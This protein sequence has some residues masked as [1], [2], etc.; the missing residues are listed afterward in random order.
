MLSVVVLLAGGLLTWRALAVTVIPAGYDQFTTV[1]SGGTNE[2]WP[3]LQAGFFHNKEGFGSYAVGAQTMAFTGRNAVPGFTGDT[4]IERTSS[5]TVPGST[6]LLVT[7]I[8]FIGEAQLTVSFMGGTPS[9]TY[10]VLAQESQIAP[11]TGAMAFNVNGTYN[12]SLTINREYTF[13]PGDSSQPP[14]VADSTTEHDSFGNLVFPPLDLSGGGTWSPPTAASAGPGIQAESVNSVAVAVASPSRNPCLVNPNS[15]A[16]LLA[17][18]G[19]LP[20]GCPTPSPSPTITASP[21]P[22]ATV[23]PTATIA[24]GT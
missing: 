10:T 19:I 23:K 18:H 11:S 16:G 20:C 7:G 6:A 3:A 4:V 21:L 15:E 13:V 12:S 24:P 17:S 8:R 1:G 22:S 5:V 9:I 2:Q 14:R